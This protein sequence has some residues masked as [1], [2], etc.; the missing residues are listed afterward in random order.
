MGYGRLPE[1]IEAFSPWD[2]QE[3]TDRALM[4]RQMARYDDLLYR[5][6]SV[7][8]FTASA[9]VM[10][11]ARDRVLMVYHNIYRSWSWPGG[12]ADGE[13][14]LLAVAQREVTEETGLTRLT[15]LLP[16]IF[17]LEIIGVNGHMKRGAHVSTHL[18]LNLTYL[19]EADPLEPLRK[20]PDENRAV[21]WLHREEV[22]ER[23]TEPD[24]RVFYR[25]ALEK[26]ST[27]PF[28]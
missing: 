24:M 12:H 25:K 26:L 16:G 11:P 20:K 19:L 28:G 8:H 9:W 1:Q 18:H 14:D 17:S 10:T 4:L 7:M 13:A 6:N 23:S 21:A 5:D 22:V 3:Q 15:P 27:T 2:A